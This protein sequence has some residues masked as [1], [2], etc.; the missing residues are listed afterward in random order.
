LRPSINE[1]YLFVHWQVE[2]FL[3]IF[4]DIIAPV[5]WQLENLLLDWR[6]NL[7]AMAIDHAKVTPVML[8]FVG[9]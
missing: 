3:G 8:G 7:L 5:K 2:T 6:I 9:G 4:F 1:T